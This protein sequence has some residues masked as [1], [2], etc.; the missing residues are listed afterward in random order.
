MVMAVTRVRTDCDQP[1]T[2]HAM[3]VPDGT[4]CDLCWQ[5]RA[6]RGLELSW[7]TRAE[8]EQREAQRIGA[9]RLQQAADCEAQGRCEDDLDASLARLA[10]AQAAQEIEEA[11]R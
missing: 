10:D 11:Q 3:A 6:T 5:Y 1:I 9:D 4:Y 7:R 8:I 2:G